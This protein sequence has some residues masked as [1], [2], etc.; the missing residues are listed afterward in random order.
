M[1]RF[2]GIAGT[3]NASKWGVQ[4]AESL[5]KWLMDDD[6][7]TVLITGGDEESRE[8]GVIDQCVARVG[9]ALAQSYRD[10]GVEGVRDPIIHLPQVFPS[11]HPRA[12]RLVGVWA[13]VQRNS[14]VVNDA[15]D[16][17][18]VIW[19][20][21]STGT[22]DVI[23]KALKQ[24]RLV[25]VI[26]ENGMVWEPSCTWNAIEYGESIV[27]QLSLTRL[28]LALQLRAQANKRSKLNRIGGVSGGPIDTKRLEYADN[29]TIHAFNRL[30]KG[31]VPT[32]GIG[33]EEGFWLVKSENSKKADVRPHRIGPDGWCDCDAVTKGRKWDSKGHGN[34]CHAMFLVWMYLKLISPMEMPTPDEVAE[35]SDQI[36]EA[37]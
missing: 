27:S 17:V 36:Q 25:Q 19:N 9:R 31:D 32:A 26:F 8:G 20:G 21:Q 10:G 18:Y 13:G 15:V 34:P 4:R 23:R 22:L 14:L 35:L 11:D 2:I 37:S 30:A 3:R 29:Q 33:E 28:A 6:P 12:G 24:S 1:T 5:V 7:W 16:G